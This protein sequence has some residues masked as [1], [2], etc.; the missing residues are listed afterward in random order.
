MYDCKCYVLIKFQSDSHKTDKFQKLNS[1]VYIEFLIEYVF[2]N[3]Y[4]V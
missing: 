3:V 4:R 2:I 1:Y